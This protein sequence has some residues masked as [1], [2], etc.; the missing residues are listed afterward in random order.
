MAV[1]PPDLG[2]PCHHQQAAAAIA[3]EVIGGWVQQ[4]RAQVAHREMQQ[5]IAQLQPQLL[6]QV[7]RSLEAASRASW[8][9]GYS[10]R[11]CGTRRRPRSSATAGWAPHSSTLVAGQR[12]AGWLATVAKMVAHTGS[13]ASTP[14]RS[15]MSANGRSARDRPAWRAGRHD[16]VG[17]VRP[18][19]RRDEAVCCIAH[20]TG[21]TG[22]S[23][24]QVSGVAGRACALND[25]A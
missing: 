9:V 5:R 16:R 7:P 1:Y 21:R 13:M 3:R 22:S 6:A 2:Q 24:G 17:V 18:P 12:L 20:P 8:R 25:P 23:P 15:Q 19:R 11:K 10:G 14:L 4:P